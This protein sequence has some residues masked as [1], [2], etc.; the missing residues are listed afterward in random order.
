MS[1]KNPSPEHSL[2]VDMD[3]ALGR[4]A[5][6]HC[7]WESLTLDAVDALHIQERARFGEQKGE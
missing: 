7:Q 3:Y 6:R 5:T 2:V 4:V 1:R